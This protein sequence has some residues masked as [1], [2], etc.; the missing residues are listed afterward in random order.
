MKILLLG[1]YSNV[2]NTLAQGLR[3]LGHEVTVASGGDGWKGYPRDIDLFHKM[4]FPG[5]MAFVW[6]VLKALPRL[7]GYDVVQLINPVFLEVSPWPLPFIYRYLRR[8]NKKVVMGAFGMDYYWVKVNRELRPMRYSDFNIGDKVRTDAVAQ[9]DVDTWIGTDAERL[10]RYVAKDSDAIVAGLY[11]YW[12]TYQLA[13]DGVL[14]NKT[15]FIPFPIPEN[16]PC[17]AQGDRIKIF[18]G[19][20]KGRS[21]Y[22]GTDIMLRAARRLEQ[23][24]PD[25]VELLVA[26]GVPFEQYK[27]MMDGSDA[28][29]DQLYSYT[30]AMNALLAMS[31][32]IVCVGGGEQEHYDLLE[33]NELRPIVNVEP[34]EESVYNSLEQLV[35]HPER[36]PELKRQSVEYV[37][38]HHNVEKV[39]KEYERLYLSLI[40]SPKCD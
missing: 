21:Q 28:I 38:K 2:H 26:E 37:R 24:Y 23:A 6:R 4:S 13:E 14:K 34:D 1:E 22:K 27:S 35:L 19:I 7:R 8:N 20:S 15:T 10:C 29:L 25:K 11:E 3:S 32:G 12:I 39:A 31:K 40:A 18:V 36:L 9:A 16:Q 5:H 17:S 33:E 30:P